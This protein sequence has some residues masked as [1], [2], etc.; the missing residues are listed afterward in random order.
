M[1]GNK[2][3]G[4]GV[5]SMFISCLALAAD[6]PPTSKPVD[7]GIDPT[8]WAGKWKTNFGTLETT[9]DKLTIS[10]AYTWD[11]GKLTGLIS[12]NGTEVIG[13]WSESPDYKPP[14]NAGKFSWKMSAGGDSFTGTWGY[15]DSY[16][17]GSRGGTWTGTRLKASE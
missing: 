11:K 14:K 16:T 8:K 2:W 4:L 5:V 6:K 12:K 10:G 9:T 3:L 7:P 1:F 17:D 15:G 13:T